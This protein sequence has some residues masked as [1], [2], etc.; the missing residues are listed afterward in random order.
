MSSDVAT[1][2]NVGPWWLILIEGILAVIIGVL[3][4]T[5]P[6]GASVFLVQVLGIYWL[7]KGVFM[8]ISMFLDSTMWGWKLFS[9]IVGIIAGFL[10]ISN[11]YPLLTTLLV[12]SVAVIVL[13]IQGLIMGIVYI[14][15]AFKG[16]GWGPG[17]LGALSVAIG[18][19]LLA[20]ALIGATVLPFVLGSFLLVGGIIAIVAAFKMR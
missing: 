7:I 1:V 12:F 5:N 13:G 20:N 16:G 14:V 8:I 6:V 11:E 3:L 15:I 19:I 18:A 10:I 4:F 9:G 2:E 17:I